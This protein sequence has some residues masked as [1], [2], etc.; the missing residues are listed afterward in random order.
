MSIRIPFLDLKAQYQK[1]KDEVD[2]E[3]QNVVDSCAFINGPA[4]K[5]F[6]KN[7]AEYCGVNFAV[8]VGNGTDAIFLALKA[9]GISPGDE[10]ITAPN[11]FIATTEAI[12]LTGA[13]PVFVDIH[14]ATYNIDVTKIEAAITGKTKAIVPVH[15]FG[16]PADMAPILNIAKKHNLKIVED[17][18]QAHGAMYK[19]KRVG[20]FGDVA[21]FSF[22]PGK[23]LGAYGD[24]GAV[25]TNNEEIAQKVVMLADHGSFNKYEHK[26]EGVNSRLDSVQAAVLDVKLKYIDEWNELRRE[27]AYTYNKFLQGVPGIVVP[28][29]LRETKPVYHLYVVQV[30][31]RDKIRDLL[32]EDGIASG[33]HYPTALHQQPAYLYLGYEEGSFPVAEAA[34][35]KYVSL[36]MYPEL[37]EPMIEHVCNSLKK[38]VA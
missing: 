19:G 2:V 16:Q 22:Y 17:A 3:I 35:A 21:C 6:N 27:N 30:N 10:V 13:R 8:G 37:T 34:V 7:F 5:K 31:E 32:G 23:N 1:I 28:S 12:S 33:I 38:Y 26:F 20:G 24:G 29:E 9:I 14:P 36:P 11:T 4:V 18:A 15:L 25:V